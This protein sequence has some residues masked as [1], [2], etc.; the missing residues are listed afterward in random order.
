MCALECWY[1][2]VCVCV[3][4]CECTESIFF[5]MGWTVKI[6]KYERVEQFLGKSLAHRGLPHIVIACLGSNRSTGPLQAGGTALGRGEDR[7]QLHHRGVLTG[8]RWEDKSQTRKSART[9]TG[10]ELNLRYLHLL[11]ISGVDESAPTHCIKR[12]KVSVWRLSFAPNKVQ[13]H[14]ESLLLITQELK[15]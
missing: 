9:L 2:S 14:L 4:V 7:V 6:N 3:C 11:A 1:V 8:G 15:I 10:R 5:K 12:E 13:V